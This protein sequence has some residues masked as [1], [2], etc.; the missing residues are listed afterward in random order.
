MSFNKACLNLGFSANS[1]LIKQDSS[2]NNSTKNKELALNQNNIIT[3]LQQR[4]LS[5]K[6]N[7]QSWHLF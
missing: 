2:F 4:H 7:L 3:L 5:S 1:N 6:L